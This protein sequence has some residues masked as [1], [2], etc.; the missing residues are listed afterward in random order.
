MKLFNKALLAA[1]ALCLGFGATKAQDV[2]VKT[3]L[4]YDATASINLGAEVGIA[5]QLSLDVNGDMNFWNVGS[6]RW[7]HWF[8]QP[9]LR[10]WL[11]HR[12]LGHFFGVHLHGGQ[13]NIGNLQTKGFK[14]LGTDFRNLDH[15]RYQGWFL[16]AGIAYGY[17]WAFNEHWGLEAEIGLGWAY[18]RYDSYPCANCG[19]KIDDDADHNYVG[20]TKAAINLVYNF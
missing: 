2:A 10:Y 7:R 6:R 1:A 12:S 9:E 19:R 14:F 11:C 16:G 3:N 13:Y 8:V 18:S 15:R 20:P 5:R 17:S 4:L